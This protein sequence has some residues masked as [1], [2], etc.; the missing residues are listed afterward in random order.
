MQIRACLCRVEAPEKVEEWEQDPDVLDMGLV[1]F[2][3]NG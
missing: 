2:M 3:A 1:L